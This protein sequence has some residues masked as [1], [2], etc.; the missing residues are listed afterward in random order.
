MKLSCTLKAKLKAKQ[1]YQRQVLS[2][3]ASCFVD[4]LILH[5]HRVLVMLVIHIIL[6]VLTHNHS[7][8]LEPLAVSLHC[9]MFVAVVIPLQP[10]CLRCGSVRSP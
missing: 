8:D 5:Q 3:L 9:D 4:Q 1:S 10:L 7:D 2:D 6:H